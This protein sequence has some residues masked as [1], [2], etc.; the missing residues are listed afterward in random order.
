MEIVASPCVLLS[1]LPRKSLDLVVLMFLLGNTEIVEKLTSKSVGP[2][3]LLHA[4][5]KLFFF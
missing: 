5:A 2:L 3:T 1:S 4:E